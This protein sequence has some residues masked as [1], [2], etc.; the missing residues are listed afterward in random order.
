[1]T[2]PL[3][4]LEASL[5]AALPWV[6]AGALFILLVY[7]LISQRNRGYGTVIVARLASLRKT[8][9]TMLARRSLALTLAPLVLL[10][11]L[12]A[13]APACAASTCDVTIKV[14]S[15]GLGVE[16][17]YVEVLDA[18]KNVVASGTTD[19]NGTFTASNLTVG[20]KYVAY[21]LYQGKLYAEGFTASEGLTVTV[22]VGGY[23][24][25]LESNWTLLAIGAGIGVFVVFI[26]LFL[27]GG[28][29][30]R[31]AASVAAL[32]PILLFVG[33]GVAVTALLVAQGYVEAMDAALA[34]V[35]LVLVAALI[36]ALSS[37]VKG[38]SS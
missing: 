6:L 38:R 27:A 15:Q 18:L 7:A 11:L 2:D 37:K 33:A 20:A 14:V 34:G 10:V 9:K 4:Q 24:S 26:A 22:N 16:G 5:E 17:A 21:V 25:W 23:T 29:R 12:V 19:A 31:A 13:L 1:M 32:L 3:G 8:G 28:S 30:R 35:V 36:P